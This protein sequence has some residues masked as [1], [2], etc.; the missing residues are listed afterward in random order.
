MIDLHSH[1]IPAVD[2]GAANLDES[3]AALELIL[4]RF[5]PK[6]SPIPNEGYKIILNPMPTPSR[7]TLAARPTKTERPIHAS[8][9]GAAAKELLDALRTLGGQA[10]TR[11]IAEATGKSISTVSHTLRAVEASKPR[12]VTRIDRGVWRLGPG[13]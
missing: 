4:A 5:P 11:Q 7:P 13:S 8:P 3:R 10:T 9:A 6:P 12:L 1:L 2:D